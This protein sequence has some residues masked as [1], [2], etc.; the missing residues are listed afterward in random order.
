[1]FEPLR[2]DCI[3]F[4]WCFNPSVTGIGR[5]ALAFLSFC[6]NNVAC[7]NGTRIVQSSDNSVL[8]YD[9]IFCAPSILFNFSSGTLSTDL[10]II[11]HEYLFYFVILVI[12]NICLSFF[13]KQMII[14]ILMMMVLTML[15]FGLYICKVIEM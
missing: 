9:E 15:M 2:F 3:F 14:L 1:M 4:T 12:K 7:S 8:S 11:F 6:T 5:L 10:I 13:T